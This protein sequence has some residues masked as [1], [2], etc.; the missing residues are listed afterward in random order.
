MTYRYRKPEVK[1]NDTAAMTA[2]KKWSLFWMVAW[3]LLFGGRGW[4]FGGREYT[5]WDKQIV[6]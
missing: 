5:G 1:K 3:K 4:N 6:G 2:A